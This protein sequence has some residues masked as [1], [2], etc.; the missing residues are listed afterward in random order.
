MLTS[1]LKSLEHERQRRQALEMELMHLRARSAGGAGPSLSPHNSLQPLGLNRPTSPELDPLNPLQ[2]LLQALTAHGALSQPEVPPP[3]P[4]PLPPQPTASAELPV[5]PLAQVQTMIRAFGQELWSFMAT[6]SMAQVQH[7]SGEVP[8]EKLLHMTQMVKMGIE[9]SNLVLNA[10]GTDAEVLIHD[11]A[12]PVLPCA[13]DDA[14][15]WQA[16]VTAVALTPSQCAR[17]AHWR[18]NFLSQIDACYGRRVALKAQALQA[19]DPA[20]GAETRWAEGL[21]LQAAGSSGFALS[22]QADAELV[23]TADAL[24]QNVVE[25]RSAA[26]AALSELLLSILTPA[27]AVRYLATSHPVSWNALA[28]SQ[29]AVATHNQPPGGPSN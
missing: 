1:Q 28:F 26:L 9:L 18:A 3:P 22:A 29:A 6:N 12:Q 7:S 24:K 20:Q 25:N 5:I 11:G 8:E 23:T 21:L 17:V 27:Q 15:R 13:A 4:P 2:T 14:H 19:M 16:V 10:T